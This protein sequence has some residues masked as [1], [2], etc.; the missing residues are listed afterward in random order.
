VSQGGGL[1][2]I[3]L[4]LGVEAV[5]HNQTVCH[6]YAVGLHGVAR[7]VGV[8]SHIRVVK[9]GHFLGGCT[10]GGRVF[11]AQHLLGAAFAFHDGVSAPG[12]VSGVRPWRERNRVRGFGPGGA[13]AGELANNERRAPL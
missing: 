11:V 8:V 10:V 6:P 13:M 5:V 12:R 1:A 9:V 2:Y 7:N 3:N 4:H